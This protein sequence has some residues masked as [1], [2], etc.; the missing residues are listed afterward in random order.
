MYLLLCC[1]LPY[2][3]LFVCL[4]LFLFNLIAINWTYKRILILEDQKTSSFEKISIMI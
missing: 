3:V 1:V 2:F 4:L